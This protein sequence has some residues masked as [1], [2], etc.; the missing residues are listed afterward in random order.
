MLEAKAIKIISRKI[1]KALK[2]PSKD[3]TIYWDSDK[4]LE[5]Y[6]WFHLKSGIY[7]SVNPILRINFKGPNGYF[8]FYPPSAKF[9]TPPYH[10]NIYEGGS[11]CV[12]IFSQDSKWSPQN[13]IDTIATNMILL[14]NDHNTSSPAN[15]KAGR[16]YSECMKNWNSY[17]KKYVS[18]YK[19][20]PNPYE[21]DIYFKPF[22][23]QVEKHFKKY[24][25]DQFYRMFPKL[26]EIT[27]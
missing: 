6:F 15:S 12:D 3:Y 16:I 27:A 24:K 25:M 13:G 9:I 18:Q 20:S 14:F 21:E 1:R 8:P 10:T 4:P 26:K 19:K 2:N 5:C 7:S 23:E 17:K 11:I 22:K